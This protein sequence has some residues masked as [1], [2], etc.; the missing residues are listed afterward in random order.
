M[1]VYFPLTVV[2]GIKIQIK[3]APL[4]SKGHIKFEHTFTRL[5]A[6]SLHVDK[7]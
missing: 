2:G 1:L 6:V 5:V 4:S 3:N 7:L